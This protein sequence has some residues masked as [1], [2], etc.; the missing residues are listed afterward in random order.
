MSG[1]N[2]APIGAATAA[3]EAARR[4][5]GTA[6][7]HLLDALDHLASAA[8]ILDALTARRAQQDAPVAPREGVVP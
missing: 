2:H 7:R 8:E 3:V 5:V 6:D 1:T 4:Q